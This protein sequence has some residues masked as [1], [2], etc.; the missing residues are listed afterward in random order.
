MKIAWFTP[1]HTGSAIGQVGKMVC[2]ELQKTD[3]V[4]VWT[5]NRENVIETS[6]PIEY[7]NS[8]SVD[9]A[10][11]KKYDHVIYNMGNYAGNHKQIWDVMQKHEGILLLHDQIMHQFFVELSFLREYGGNP[12]T[13]EETY[14]KIMR[15]CY[16]ERGEAAGKATYE[17][18][19]GEGRVR[20]WES[21]AALT[22]PLFEVVLNKATAVFTHASFFVE[23]LRDYFYGPMGYAYLPH[24]SMLV[25]EDSGLPFENLNPEKV[26]VVT[27]GI[28]HPIKRIDRV[29]EMLL[30][31]PDIARKVQYVVVGGYGGP[32]GEYL[33]HLADGPLQGCLYLL[34]YQPDDIMTMLLQKADFCVNLRYPNSEV[35]SKA[36]IEQMAFG[37]PVIVLTSGIFGEMPDD[38]VFKINLENET[39]ELENAFRTLI[40]KKDIRDDIGGQAALF[41]E[42]NCTAQEYVKRLKDFLAGIDPVV[43]GNK[44]VYDL[45]QINRWAL[46]DLSFNQQ[47]APGVFHATWDQLSRVCGAIDVKPDN[48]KVLGI[49]LGFPYIVP[50]LR[51]E[52]ITRFL[53]YMLMAMLE[54]Y[55]I[56]CELWTY[57]FNEQEV[58][59]GF[60]IVL[61]DKDFEN[62]VKV[63]TEK[64]YKKALN[65]SPYQADVSWGVDE[66][67]DNL[68]EVAR[69][70]SKASSF[71]TAIVYLDNVIG[72]GKPIFVPVHDLSI[73]IHYDDFVSKDPLYKARFIDIRSRAE[74]LAR[75]GAH[76]F[77][78]SEFVRQNH[79]LKHVSSITADRTAVI[80]LPVN[81][82]K[83]IENNL[84]KEQD[85]REKFHL[86]RPY[87]FYPT[88]IRPYKNVT[89]LVR[90]L[91]IL[92][93]RDMDIEL[94]LTGN[95][96][97]VPEVEM[98]IDRLKIKN[99]IVC[100]PPVTEYELLSLYRYAAVAAVPT[101][102]EG[103]FPW[104]ACEALFMDAPLVLSKIPVV[105]ER[106]EFTGMSPENCGLLLFDPGDPAE[107]AV[108]IAKAISNRDDTLLSQK[109]FK[110]RLLSYSWFDAIEKYY[111]IFFE[112]QDISSLAKK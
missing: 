76:M 59:L 8:R 66:K 28:V 43:S 13:G 83:N 67:L 34:G 22:Y 10:R 44:V 89:V 15:G 52:G 6:V 51:R 57:S 77:S 46:R 35:C 93:H 48:G 11:L 31:N 25:K 32:Y 71:V 99:H 108:G 41:V 84:V 96:A 24:V 47:N 98:E 62:R 17:P 7:F 90:A 63:I 111:S 33:K 103:G 42:K 54:R 38:I 5:F 106:I 80:Y 23:R 97:D 60:E 19:F 58:R 61:K 105:E 37:N 112:G 101:L 45:I 20:I 65:I 3:S 110:N 95:P 56:N 12:I 18:S 75:S 104:Q 39:L 72:T 16:G 78:N 2:E 100:L 85:I 30:A 94:V 21:N 102:F 1:F 69:E 40:D 64:N 91:S 74:R 53:S 50:H 27:N 4:D 68:S 79:V 9:L 86:K 92:K 26:L 14:L 73:H 87:I 81:I 36:L 70:F 107:C 82:P 29:A 55:P 88:Q 49:W 109:E